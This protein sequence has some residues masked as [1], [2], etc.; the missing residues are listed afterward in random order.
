MNDD[1]S[2]PLWWKDIFI[3]LNRDKYIKIY[4]EDTSR[5]I[6]W[7]LNEKIGSGI[8]GPTGGV[9]LEEE[10]T[11]NIAV[12]LE[13]VLL[14]FRD[15]K[16]LLRLTSETQH[17][18]IY[19]EHLKYFKSRSIEP[20]FFETN[21]EINLKEEL[22]LSRNRRRELKHLTSGYGDLTFS[23]VN[24]LLAYEILVRNRKAKGLTFGLSRKTFMS[25]TVN[26]SIAQ[27]FAFSSGR[28]ILSVAL[29]LNVDQ[30]ITHVYAWGHDPIIPDS[31]RSVTP[32][33]IELFNHYKRAG[34]SILCLGISSKEGIINEGLFRFKKELGAYSAHKPVY[35]IKG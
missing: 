33:A 26:N 25:L 35:E 23:T 32:L 31:K 17:P 34:K 11:Q 13:K 16:I 19:R 14:D 2:R 12:L 29:C 20:K 21:Q 15:E 7:R 10:G 9:Y 30:N 3:N 24:P 18:L 4:Q 5:L 22:K 28:T 8:I 27:C 6:L 1:V